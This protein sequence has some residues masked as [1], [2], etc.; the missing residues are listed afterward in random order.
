MKDTG[1]DD[2]TINSMIELFGIIRP[3]YAAT[4]SPTVEQITG[5]RP[6][7]I[8]HAQV[9]CRRLPSTHVLLSR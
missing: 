6:I 7:G 8:E 9:C 4:I 2:W 5:N 1:A 3:G